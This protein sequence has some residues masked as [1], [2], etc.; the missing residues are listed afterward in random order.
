MTSIGKRL[1]A[2]TADLAAS[3]EARAAQ[4]ESPKPPLPRTA[5]GQMLAARSEMLSMQGELQSLRDKL[6]SFDGS[7]P[8][9]KLDASLVDATRWANRHATAFTTAAFARLKSSIELAGGNTQPILVRH[10]ETAGRYEIV[11]GHR[12]HRACLELG[13]PVLAVVWDGEMPDLDLFLSMDRE[14]REREDPSAYEQ[15]TTYLAALDA[16][17]F[18]SQRRLAEAIGV[19]H[20]W[21]RK[22]TLVAQLPAAIV[23]TFET[24]LDIQP[25]HAEEITQALDQDRKAVLRRAERVRQMSRR[26]SPGQIV[27]HLTGR[28]AEK[29]APEKFHVGGRLAGTW[30]R[31]SRGRAVITLEAHVADEVFMDELSDIV[32]KMLNRPRG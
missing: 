6:K 32:M 10:S 13:L 5:P 4:S 27:A 3:L 25:R 20:T 22:A 28:V 14:N 12:R 23:E 8:T 16:G 19:S 30:T 2:T 18:P 15:G 17:L 26:P 1:L 11:F 31:D 7:L 21:V 9:L 24:P 29:A